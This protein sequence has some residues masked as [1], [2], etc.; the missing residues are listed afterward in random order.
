MVITAA[1]AIRYLQRRAP[2]MP[3]FVLLGQD[4]FA[5]VLVQSWA[6]T[7]AVNTGNRSDH[8]QTKLDNARETAAAMEKWPDRK[9]P[10]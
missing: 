7:V 9:F 4:R 2:D 1:E 10:D 5:P 3:V 6:H 8:L